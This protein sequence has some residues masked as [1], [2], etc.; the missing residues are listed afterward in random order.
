MIENIL[1]PLRRQEV[2]VW[3][4]PVRHSQA[5][6][7]Q[8]HS[9]TSSTLSSVID[10]EQSALTG[11]V[12][13]KRRARKAMH[14][15]EFNSVIQFESQGDVATP[16][17][18][19]SDRGKQNLAALERQLRIMHRQSDAWKQAQAQFVKLSQSHG[20]LCQLFCSFGWFLELDHF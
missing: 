13:G 11:P 19:A 2:D 6:S 15:D 10:S 8:K 16:S 18:S 17:G 3:S 5:P 14:W 1:R 20:L 9:S 12:G 7:P 4:F